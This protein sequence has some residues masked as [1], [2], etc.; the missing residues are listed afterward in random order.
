MMFSWF[1]SRAWE[2]NCMYPWFP[3]ESAVTLEGTSTLFPTY[4]L[5]EMIG[6]RLAWGSKQLN[7]PCI[8]ELLK[9]AEK[10]SRDKSCVLSYSPALE[11]VPETSQYV[12][13]IP[14]T[15]AKLFSNKLATREWL[16]SNALPTIEANV[17]DKKSGWPS[18][19][20]FAVMQALEG[21]CGTTTYIGPQNKLRKH[22]SDLSW[23]SAIVS[24]FRKGVVIN[25]H[26]AIFPNGKIEIPWPSIQ[27]VYFVKSNGLI[28]PV[29]AGNDYL[30]YTKDVD[31]ELNSRIHSLL[32]RLGNAA[33]RLNYKGMLGADLLCDID[34]KNLHFLEVHARLQGSSGL[35]TCLEN[36][37]GQ[38]PTIVRI[39]NALIGKSTSDKII[40]DKSEVKRNDPFA[41]QLILR[42]G[43]SELIGCI[44]DGIIIDH[45]NASLKIKFLASIGRLLTKESICLKNKSEIFQKGTNAYNYKNI[46]P[47][48]SG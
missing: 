37:L 12:W 5:E 40:K 20:G 1:G 38:T 25:A 29:Y 15:V 27:L 36:S 35:L 14:Q 10:D 42:K 16:K 22:F 46:S 45:P 24:P 9:Q 21:S 18:Q 43:T 17:V 19:G 33:R 6:E 26:V 44:L 30:A 3:F 23:K 31:F 41:S 47:I 2:A 34:A 8:L 48:T 11:E 39:F 4:S 7:E 13:R 28:R 32:H